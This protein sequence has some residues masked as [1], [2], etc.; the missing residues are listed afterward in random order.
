MDDKKIIYLKDIKKFNELFKSY[1]NFTIFGKGST[2]IN[3]KKQPNEL[4]C[5]INQAS[6]FVDD[7][8][9]VCIN[10]L[11]NLEKI[12]D[13]VYKNL[14]FILI[15]EYLHINMNATFK[16]HWYKVYY[17]LKELNFDGYFIVYNLLSSPKINKKLITMYTQFSSS[18]SCFEFFCLF[19]NIKICN[20]YGVGIYNKDKN[21][22]ENFVGNGKYIRIRIDKIRN[23]ILKLA[24]ENK[25]TV[26]FN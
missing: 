5:S 8:D 17:Y 1:N 6:N 21:Y 13:K 26:K 20:L 23:S 25:V 19:T 12:S 16:G 15:P 3:K 14:K 9:L 11:H 2:F 4:R 10:D 24:N 22:H 18:N 7:V